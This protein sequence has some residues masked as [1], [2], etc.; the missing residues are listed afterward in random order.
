MI[1]C[2]YTVL[3]DVFLL[4]LRE[5]CVKGLCAQTLYSAWSSWLLLLLVVVV[6]VVVLWAE[7]LESAS[8][9]SGLG[10]SGMGMHTVTGPRSWER[11][12]QRD[13]VRERD[14]ERHR[15]GDRRKQSV[16]GSQS[17]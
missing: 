7:S 13:T 10:V 17:V 8:I 2:L 5:L 11:D 16:S 15:E 9:S 1:R 12:T 6:V 3:P 14:T 4:C